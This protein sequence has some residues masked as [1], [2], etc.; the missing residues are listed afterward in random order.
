MEYV[1]P[2]KFNQ[3]AINI[4]K[5]HSRQLREHLKQRCDVNKQKKQCI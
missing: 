1:K 2:Q 5:K 3:H 4:N